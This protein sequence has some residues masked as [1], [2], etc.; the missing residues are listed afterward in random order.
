MNERRSNYHSQAM[1][2]RAVLI[3]ILLTGS[4]IAAALVIPLVLSMPMVRDAFLHEFG[5][6]TGHRLTTER[7]DFHLLPRPRLDLRQ[8]ELFDRTSEAPLFVADRLDIALQI[9]PLL[10]GR[11][12]GEYVVVERPRMLIRH[13]ETG[14]WT[15][16]SRVLEASPAKTATPFLPVTVVRNVLITDGLVTIA[17]EARSAQVEP[18]QLAS[19]Q[20]TIAE[21][22][23]GR[24]ARIQISGKIPQGAGS[25]FFNVDGSLVLLH[26]ADSTAEIPES[27]QGVQV[28][29]SVRINQLDVR[30][31]AGWLGMPPISTGFAAPAQLVAQVR[32][33]PRPAGYDLIVGEWRAGLLDMSFQGTAS[34]TDLGTATPRFSA[35]FSSLPMTLKHV[36][37]QV[38][39]SWMPAWLR[40]TVE[41]HGIDG[42]I[43]VRESQAGGFLKDDMQLW[44]NGSLD[45]LEG[46]FSP[47]RDSPTIREVSAKVLYDLKQI[48]IV[49]LRANYGPARFSEGTVVI[50][51]WSKDPTADVRISG[52]GPAAGLLSLLTDRM[53]VPQLAQS[54]DQF[55]QV[56]GE[57]L[58]VAHV[59]GRPMEADGMRLVNADVMIRNVGFRHPVLP[60]PIR[61]IHGTLKVSPSEIRVESLHGLAGPAQVEARGAV[62]LTGGQAVQVMTIEV[63]GEGEDLT[64]FLHLINGEI[65]KSKIEGPVLLS[66]RTTGDVWTPRFKGTLTLDG[67]ALEIPNMFS[68]VRGAPTGFQFDAQLTRDLILVVQR[69]ELVIPPVRFA[70]T[71]R[72]RL[73]GGMEFEST[74]SSGV[75]SLNRLPE[76]V[77]LG[78]IKTGILR[79]GLETKGKVGDLASWDTTG[80]LRFSKGTVKMDRLLNPIRDM[81]MV[82]HFDRQNID[83]RH[84]M[85]N[86]G[87]SDIR[88]TGSID[89][90]LAAP[91]GKLVVQSS[92]VD[93][94]SF[95]TT[96]KTKASFPVFPIL[97]SWW[98][99]GRVDATL[100]IDHVYYQRFLLSGFSS[101]VSFEHGVLRVDRI[102]ADTSEGHLKGRVVVDQP[103]AMT[104]QV[105]S[106]FRGSGIP[107]DRL[108]SFFDKEV[109]LSGWLS[110]SGK[111]QGEFERNRLLPS[112][113]ASQRPIQVV[114][115]EGR[116]FNVPV[117]SKLLSIMNLPAL[118]QGKIDLIK[119]GMPLDRS[120]A[121]MA[122]ENGSILIKELLLDSPVLKISGTGRYDYVDDEFDM[123]LVTSPLGHYAAM[124]KTIPLFGTLFAGERQGLRYG[125]IRSQRSCER[126]RSSFPAGGIVD[127]RSEGNSPIG[128]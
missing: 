94:Q 44:V 42:L 123:L 11:V 102:S 64:S 23:P 21:E 77:T 55:E 115:E 24:T 38:P 68:K 82:L 90:W 5:Q 41:E 28:E 29:G 4:F 89:H 109:L 103:K 1:K 65:S 84:V 97:T 17:D 110:A 20:A 93:L 14:R 125:D 32:L 87:D 95:Q 114:I 48:R 66:V 116:I 56:T 2:G 63:S 52:E 47:G 50:T 22:I 117:I 12:V 76:G 108:L 118:L 67:A 122:V 120:K 107:V 128:L 54:V 83:V 27:A 113:L 18:L 91:R 53:R 7:L 81:S 59:A 31:M 43:I 61:Q 57:V 60:V 70:G 37:R 15:V 25:A 26:G 124:L 73:S 13:D 40:A 99:G 45:I 71:A 51:D 46:R 105:R 58:M 126:S 104:G 86:I 121:V 79:V 72:I 106:Y 88:I 33:V 9:W 85:F 80:R 35:S 49:G 16:G 112:S 92:Q 98:A 101:H 62:T 19:L 6:R 69:C 3:L 96:G 34:L 111:I 75:V 78:P 100:F 119:E 36:L 127:D 10:E 8:V 74:I 30:H 39:E